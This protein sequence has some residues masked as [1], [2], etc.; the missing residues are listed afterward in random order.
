ML[1]TRTALH[2]GVPCHV[3]KGSCALNQT[4]RRKTPMA[5]AAKEDVAGGCTAFAAPWLLMT[6]KIAASAGFF[7][8]FYC[9]IVI[10]QHRV[11]NEEWD[12][13]LYERA[14]YKQCLPS[15]LS[16]V[17]DAFLTFAVD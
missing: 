17:H 4:Q 2:M 9:F 7:L 15:Q 6:T 1:Q 11:G 14:L 16:P 13:A 3:R 12:L 10:L 5:T 8:F